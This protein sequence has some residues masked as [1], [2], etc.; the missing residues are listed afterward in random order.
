VENWGGEQR[1]NESS[2]AVEFKMFLSFSS[3]VIKVHTRIIQSFVR[4]VRQESK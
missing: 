4:A 2:V 3:L 1:E